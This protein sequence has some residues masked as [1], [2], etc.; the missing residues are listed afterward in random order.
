MKKYKV[1]S[2]F[3]GIGGIC[4]GFKQTGYDIVWANEID[5]NACKTYRYN[6]GCDYLIEGDIRKILSDSLPDFDILA[7]GFPC[8]PFSIAGQQRGFSDDRG[9]LFFEI[10]RIADKKRPR[11]IFLENVANLIEHDNERTFLVIHSIL[12]DLGYSIRYSTML[13]NQ[14]GN[15]PQTR[16]RVY[17]IAFRNLIDCDYFTFPN[18]IELKIKVNDIINIHE[19]KNN[20]YYY[21]PDDKIYSHLKGVI[22]EKGRIYNMHNCVARKTRYPLCPTLVASMGTRKNRVPVVLDDYGYRKLT[23]RECLDFQGFPSDF[24]FPNTITIENA[25]KQIG[26]SVCVPLIRRIADNILQTLE[27]NHNDRYME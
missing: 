2:M 26:N 3:A 20:I 8:Q 4:L 5:I 18:A 27:M 14:Y 24:K 7:A 9:N 19:K 25:Y 17:I 22:K 10:A 21:S 16:N 1:A 13:S 23:L 11:I 15:V 12:S 6:L